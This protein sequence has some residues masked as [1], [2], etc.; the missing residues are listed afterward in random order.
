MDA[1]NGPSKDPGFSAPLGTLRGDILPSPGLTPCPPRYIILEKEALVFSV[2]HWKDEGLD[3]ATSTTEHSSYFEGASDSMTPQRHPLSHGGDPE[4]GPH[5]AA[6]R[7]LGPSAPG[8][9]Q[10]TGALCSAGRP[11]RPPI[12][13]PWASPPAPPLLHL[14]SCSSALESSLPPCSSQSGPY[15]QEH[16]ANLCKPS[17]TS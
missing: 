12:M 3:D 4:H 1:L 17:V 2:G 7:R 5:S 8:G 15:R 11:A 10:R 9:A 16:I 6:C 13:P 14:L